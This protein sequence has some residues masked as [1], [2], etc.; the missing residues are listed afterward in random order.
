MTGRAGGREAPQI[1]ARTLVGGG[2][3]DTLLPVANQR[4]IAQ[5]IPNAKL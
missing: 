2:R 5:V 1:K 4:H 3:L